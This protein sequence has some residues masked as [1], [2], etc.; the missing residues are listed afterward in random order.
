[1][2]RWGIIGC[3][4]VTEVKSGP[5]FQLADGSK[6]QAVMRRDADK[7]AD[8]AKRHGVAQW[9]SSADA[10]IHD[11]AVDAVY[12]ATPVSSHMEYALQVCAAGKPCYVEK[13]PA[14]NLTECRRMQS[15]FAEAKLPLYVA[16]YRR[17]LPRFIKARELIQ[18]TALGQITG[19]NYTFTQPRHKEEHA[20]T[21]PW[22]LD[23]QHSGGGVFMDMGC[24][25][26]DILDFMLGPLENVTGRAF[27]L[28]GSYN[29]EDYVDMLFTA[30]DGA[31]GTASWNFS[32]DAREDMI[33]IT[34]TAGQLQLSTFGN[35]PL[36]LKRGTNPPE[37]IALPNPQHIQQPLIQTIVDD[38]S[39]RAECPSTI[40][41]ALR[42]AAVMD[43][44]LDEYYGGRQDAFWARPA[45]WPGCARVQRKT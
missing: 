36:R 22:R 42:T 12:I 38:L 6:L 2:I 26:L 40:A 44:V 39:G 1:M 41:T 25:T 16:Y 45:T 27:N 29:I 21:V 35:E 23:A 30:V 3:G 13:P 20:A 37:E 8:Y 5:G 43:K 28:T 18:S 11:K 14:R 4:D 9:Y 19:I 10:L 7:A 17:A 24:H 31:P 34:G 32:G 15:A 33:N